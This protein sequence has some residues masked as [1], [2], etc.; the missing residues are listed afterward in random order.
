MVRPLSSPL[1]PPQAQAALR[2]EPRSTRSLRPGRSAVSVAVNL[3]GRCVRC[4][5]N[6]V[7]VAK[8]GGAKCSSAGQFKQTPGQRLASQLARE[9]GTSFSFESENLFLFYRDGASQAL[10]SRPVFSNLL[11]LDGTSSPGRKNISKKLDRSVFPSFF[12][13]NEVA[14]KYFPG[15]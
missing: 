8:D 7:A 12:Y 9:R 1:A 15:D 6:S 4:L 2:Q 11:R 10:R 5:G 14:C 13:P 3:A